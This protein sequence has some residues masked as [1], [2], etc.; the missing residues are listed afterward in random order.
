MYRQNWHFKAPPDAYNIRYGTHVKLKRTYD[1][2]PKSWLTTERITLAASQPVIILTVGVACSAT[3]WGVMKAIRYYALA[4]AAIVL[5][6][7]GTR[8][9]SSVSPTLGATPAP[10]VGTAATKSPDQI[11]LT[12]GDITDRPYQSLGDIEV[13][14]KKWTIFDS[15]PT[16]EKVAAALKEKAAEM[17]AD[18]I[19]LARYGTVGIGFMSWGQM[20]G[21]GRAVVFKR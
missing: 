13:T 18:A 11:I 10:V 9:S 6:G 5:A 15:D 21:Q 4:M 7:C 14:V 12:E 19:V 2:G 16:R 1:G 20:D 17:G 3:K 8:T